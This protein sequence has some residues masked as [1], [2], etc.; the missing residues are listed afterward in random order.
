MAFL[1]SG[2]YVRPKLNKLSINYE[3]DVHDDDDL[4]CAAGGTWVRLL[5]CEQ[6]GYTSQ[7]GFS[8]AASLLS[9]RGGSAPRKS[10]GHKNPAS[11]AG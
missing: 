3:D 6:G 11:Y 2:R 1:W 10:P 9:S 8:L 4:A 7:F 5:Y